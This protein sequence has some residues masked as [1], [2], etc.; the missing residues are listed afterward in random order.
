MCYSQSF[1]TKLLTLGILFLTAVRALVVS[2]LVILGISPL[3]SFILALREALVAKLV[4]LGI[5]PLT[6][7]ILALR[8]VLVAKLVIS[9]ILS[10]IFFISALYTAFLTTFSLHGFVYLNQQEYV[11][12]YQHL[13]FLL[14]FSN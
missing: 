13:T 14:Y 10:S 8:V 1:F 3:D 11:L 9:G 4:I 7:F 2:K 6:S 5:S 12:I